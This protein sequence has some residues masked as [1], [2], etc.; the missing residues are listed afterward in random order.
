MTFRVYG[1]YLSAIN[2]VIFNFLIWL[3]NMSRVYI[4]PIKDLK[5]NRIAISECESMV[6][7]GGG[8]R[9]SGFFIICWSYSAGN[10]LRIIRRKFSFPHEGDL[11]ISNMHIFRTNKN[12]VDI[13]S[14]LS[15][16]HI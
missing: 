16:D 4:C 6:F 13:F 3:V 7:A 15:G 14:L 11:L 9:T 12:S 5:L 8:C 2:N 1:L 10:L